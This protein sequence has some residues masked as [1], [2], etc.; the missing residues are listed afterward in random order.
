MYGYDRITPGNLQAVA[1][2]IRNNPAIRQLYVGYYS[3]SGPAEISPTNWP[4]FACAQTELT[5]ADYSKALHAL[6]GQA[7]QSPSP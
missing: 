7:A 4:Y 3:A 1:T 5:A 6:L 2:E